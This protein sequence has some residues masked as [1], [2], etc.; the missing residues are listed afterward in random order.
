MYGR[1][2]IASSQTNRLGK[3]LSFEAIRPV[4]DMNDGVA[5]GALLAKLPIVILE[6]LLRALQARSAYGS[7]R[8]Q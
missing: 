3:P 8:L 1:E 6:K 2:V 7:A 4:F 5:P